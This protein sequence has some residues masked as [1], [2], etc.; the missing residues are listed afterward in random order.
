MKNFQPRPFL[1]RRVKTTK[2]NITADE[3]GIMPPVLDDELSL[4]QLE[5]VCGGMS[6]IIFEEW[7]CN[8]INGVH[9]EDR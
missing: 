7:C 2:G 1:L 8:Q 6:R 9:N 4:E 3:D 5:Y